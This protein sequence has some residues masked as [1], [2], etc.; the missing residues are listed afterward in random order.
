VTTV[1][2]LSTLALSERA[3]RFEGNAYGSQVSFFITAHEYGA[4]PD[5]HTHPY[6][7]TFIVKEGAAR[8]TVDGQAVDASAGQVVVVPAGAAH[9]FKG[10]SRDGSVQ[11]VSIHPVAEMD[12]TFSG[13][14]ALPPD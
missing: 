11:M 2:D 6:E 3:W 14:P 1:V 5:L 12:T 4:G 13:E 7:E 8:F 9:G 10:A